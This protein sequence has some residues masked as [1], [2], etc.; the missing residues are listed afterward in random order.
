MQPLSRSLGQG[1]G[2]WGLRTRVTVLLIMEC[3]VVVIM[4]PLVITMGGSVRVMRMLNRCGKEDWSGLVRLTQIDLLW[5]A[6]V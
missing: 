5:H 4:N 6:V 2:W 3:C 1:W